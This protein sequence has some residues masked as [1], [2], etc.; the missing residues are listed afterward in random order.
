M[1]KGEIEHG[2]PSCLQ[3]FTVDELIPAKISFVMNA[4][5]N[6]EAIAR[7]GFNPFPFCH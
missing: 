1:I 5:N 3:N 2:P 4:F 6:S 7:V